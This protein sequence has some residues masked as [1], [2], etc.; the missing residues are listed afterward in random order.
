MF[1][2]SFLNNPDPG[3]DLE[4]C[5]I[6]VWTPVPHPGAVEGEAKTGMLATDNQSYP[7]V[8]RSNV[9]YGTSDIFANT[10]IKA[11][12]YDSDGEKLIVDS[13][14]SHKDEALVLPFHPGS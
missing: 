12:T 5:G 14:E 1:E 2:S 11:L 8:A 6:P 13:R 7:G 3:D 10:V 4:L 9:H